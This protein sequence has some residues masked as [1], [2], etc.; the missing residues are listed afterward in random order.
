MQDNFISYLLGFR[1][2]SP[3]LSFQLVKSLIQS[4]ASGRVALQICITARDF[5]SQPAFAGVFLIFKQSQGRANN[6]TCVVIATGFKL[7]FDE[8]LVVFIECETCN[9]DYLLF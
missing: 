3:M 9:D 8:A 5:L 4:H 2:L 1:Q 6:F 7:P